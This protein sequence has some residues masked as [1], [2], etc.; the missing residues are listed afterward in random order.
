MI[1]Q[2]GIYARQGHDVYGPVRSHCECFCSE[3]P[4]IDALVRY[5]TNER[6]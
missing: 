2:L 5:T 6:L 3:F 4:A 1:D